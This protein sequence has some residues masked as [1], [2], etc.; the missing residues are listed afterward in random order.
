MIKK[1]NF[2][3]IFVYIL[4]LCTFFSCNNASDSQSPKD[5]TDGKDGISIIWKGAFSSADLI[6]EPEYLWA[7]YNT[8][9]GCS[10]IY[11]GEK[12]TLLAYGEKPNSTPAPNPVLDPTEVFIVTYQTTYDTAPA[13][14]YCMKGFKL[15]NE[16]LPQLQAEHYNFTGWKDGETDAP[17]GYE[18]TKN[19]VLTATWVPKKY[20]ITYVCDTI[21]PPDPVWVDY[22]TVLDASYFPEISNENYSLLSWEVNN[23]SISTGYIIYNDVTFVGITYDL[24]AITLT[25]KDS[26]DINNQYT[27]QTSAG[28]NLFETA[29]C[30]NEE[31]LYDFIISC[32][33]IQELCDETSIMIKNQDNQSI[34]IQEYKF[35]GNTILIVEWNYTEIIQSLFN[36]AGSLIWCNEDSNGCTIFA[37]LY[38]SGVT[39]VNGTE[40]ESFRPQ[41]GFVGE[42]GNPILIDAL[43]NTDYWSDGNPYNDEYYININLDP[44]Y[45]KVFFI[46]NHNFLYAVRPGG[47][48]RTPTYVK[49]FSEYSFYTFPEECFMIFVSTG[50]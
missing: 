26:K 10:Y 20:K 14:F 36:S 13:S 34:N 4:V 35:S 42:E 8:S 44:G 19:T 2:L 27:L 6:E 30:S 22:G 49:D 29:N 21:T 32:L 24:T 33:D 28:K 37:R 16:K 40:R 17:E 46:V 41:I 48:W 25:L 43:L 18:I 11:D 31:E 50:Y 5:G 1:I 23:V 12:W 39:G 7:Y 38:L 15:T 45:Y 47:D 9:D 3:K